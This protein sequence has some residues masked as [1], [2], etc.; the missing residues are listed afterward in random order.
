MKLAGLELAICGEWLVLLPLPPKWWNYRC[1]SPCLVIHSILKPIHK[2]TFKKCG[3]SCSCSKLVYWAKTSVE[4]LDLG[5]CP[6][7]FVSLKYK[8]LSFLEMLD[9]FLIACLRIGQWD[10]AKSQYSVFF[11]ENTCRNV[12]SLH[13]PTQH[14]W[15]RLVCSYQG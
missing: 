9:S 7:Y 15:V 8:L 2:T 5:L 1:L 14:G 11:G 6:I 12:I 13:L 4:S 3:F 10:W